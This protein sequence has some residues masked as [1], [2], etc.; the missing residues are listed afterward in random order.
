MP[1]VVV[2]DTSCFIALSNIGKLEILQ[3]L[4]GQIYSSEEVEA[5]FGEKLPPWINILALSDKQ[6]QQMLEFQVDKGEASAITLA[7]EIDANLIILDDYK[8]RLAA[9]KLGLEITGTLGVIIKAKKKGIISTIKPLLELLKKSAF[10]LS[11]SLTE[12]ALKEAGE[13]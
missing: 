2:S 6:K 9:E 12:E 11:D 8:G 7:L 10:R 5:E 1:K 13:Q 4:Y 3:K